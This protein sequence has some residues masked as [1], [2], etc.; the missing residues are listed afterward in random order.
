MSSPA[1]ALTPVPPLSGTGAGATTG[2]T[3]RPGHR[4]HTLCEN[5][6]GNGRAG[7]RGASRA[8]AGRERPASPF[9]PTAAPPASTRTGAVHD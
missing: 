9:L 8:F 2:T 3:R 1:L 4:Y 6:D 5:T 7:N